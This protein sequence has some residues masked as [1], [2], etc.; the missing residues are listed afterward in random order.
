[1]VE[2]G[3]NW[4]PV[5]RHTHTHRNW[6]VDTGWWALWVWVRRKTAVLLLQTSLASEEHPQRLLPLR[7]HL[8]KAG[9]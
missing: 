3:L 2:T 9:R 7:T 5:S 4:I 1:M 6:V 8:F